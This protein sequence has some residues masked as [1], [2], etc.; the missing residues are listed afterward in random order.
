MAYSTSKMGGEFQ[1]LV[2]IRKASRQ[3]LRT[4]EIHRKRR[5]QTRTL[6]NVTARNVQTPKTIQRTPK[7]AWAT[8]WLDVESQK[9]ASKKEGEKPAIEQEKGFTIG[10]AKSLERLH[11]YSADEGRACVPANY[12]TED[13]YKLGIWVR[14]QRYEHKKGNLSKEQEQALEQLPGWV[15]RQLGIWFPACVRTSF[16]RTRVTRET[17][18]SINMP[19]AG[20]IGG[21]NVLQT[22]CVKQ[23]INLDVNVRFSLTKAALGRIVSSRIKYIALRIYF[24]NPNRVQFTFEPSVRGII[25]P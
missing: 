25:L 24:N 14:D 13:G 8:S 21:G 1:S 4:T 18:T 20:R 22:P 16:T 3:C 23:E 9:R 10:W 5:L 6:G 7:N 19:S 11:K 2:W 17:G 15:W 12:V